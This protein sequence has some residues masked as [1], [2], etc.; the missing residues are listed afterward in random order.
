MKWKREKGEYETYACLSVHI[1]VEVQ[2]PPRIEMVD[3][4][5]LEFNPPV[6]ELINMCNGETLNLIASREL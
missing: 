4:I 3:R 1:T 6:A 5:F 2:N